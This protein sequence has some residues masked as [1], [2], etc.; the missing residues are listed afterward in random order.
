MD[1]PPQPA[2]IAEI[3]GS[4]G[5]TR[6]LRLS[7]GRELLFSDDACERCSVRP[8]MPV[9][10]DLLDALEAAEQRVNAHEAA[11]RLLSHRS[12]SQT[13]MRTRLKMRGIAPDAIEDEIARLQAAGLL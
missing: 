3:R 2:T 6:L 4:G 10:A 5:R 13:E 7:D 8:G 9:T 11:L 12:R 1:D